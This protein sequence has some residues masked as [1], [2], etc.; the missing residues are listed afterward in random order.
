MYY[1]V[2]LIDFDLFIVVPIF[3]IRE[4]TKMLRKFVKKG[5]NNSQTHLC[6]YS[7]LEEAQVTV[8]EENIP[9]IN[10]KPNFNIEM[11]GTFPCDAGV[12]HCRVVSFYGEYFAI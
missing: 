9:D 6:F 1:V 2:Y 8:N 4:D 12:F 7:R 3:W 10:L 5:M 11:G